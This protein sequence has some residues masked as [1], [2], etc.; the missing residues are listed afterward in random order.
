[1]VRS[2]SRR[3]GFILQGTTTPLLEMAYST[4]PETRKDCVTAYVAIG[5]NIGNR[6]ANLEMACAE[7]SKHDSIKLI[8]TS[9]L[10]LTEAMYVVD[11]DQFFNAVCEVS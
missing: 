8:K 2:A 1:V 10:Y 3:N 4:A 9:S 6:L 5:S 11:Q 7:L